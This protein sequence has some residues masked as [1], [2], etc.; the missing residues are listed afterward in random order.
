M[1]SYGFLLTEFDLKIIMKTY[2]EKAERT[3]PKFKNNTIVKKQYHII[4]EAPSLSFSWFCNK[5]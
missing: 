2:F 5:R 3:V 4:F 1:R